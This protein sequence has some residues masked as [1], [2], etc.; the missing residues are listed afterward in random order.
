MPWPARLGPTRTPSKR[1]P[2][3]GAYETAPSNAANTPPE[4]PEMALRPADWD[5]SALAERAEGAGARQSWWAACIGRMSGSQPNC[6]ERACRDA[7]SLG[8]VGGASSCASRGMLK[9]ACKRRHAIGYLEPENFYISRA[10]WLLYPR[11][12]VPAQQG[13][14]EVSTDIHKESTHGFTSGDD[15]ADHPP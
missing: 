2:A 4:P 15:G 6:G 8:V 13:V 12:K 3:G 1:Q 10:G 7:R 5:E 14:A 11:C 9:R